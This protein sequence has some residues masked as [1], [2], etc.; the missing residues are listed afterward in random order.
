MFLT[1]G[2]CGNFY[3]HLRRSYRSFYV[4]CYIFNRFIVILETSRLI[5]LVSNLLI[6]IRK[7]Y[8]INVYN[9]S[10]E[11]VLLLGLIIY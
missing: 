1:F 9:Y 3:S 10:M 11:L 7:I 8:K 6:V 5:I 2:K 4:L